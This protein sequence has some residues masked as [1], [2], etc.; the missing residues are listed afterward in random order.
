MFDNTSDKLIPMVLLVTFVVTVLIS[1]GEMSSH[2][3]VEQEQAY[4]FQKGMTIEGT[5]KDNV[6]NTTHSNQ[7]VW[8]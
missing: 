6:I 1:F 3:T 4:V 8:I 2:K 7:R 5:G